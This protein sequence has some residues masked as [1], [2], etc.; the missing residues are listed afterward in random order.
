MKFRKGTIEEMVI[1]SAKA[2]NI[3]VKR[4]KYI[5]VLLFPSIFDHIFLTNWKLSLKPILELGKMINIFGFII[6]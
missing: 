5:C 6:S 4:R 1:I 3:I 2:V